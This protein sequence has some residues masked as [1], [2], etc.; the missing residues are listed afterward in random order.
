MW[1]PGPVRSGE[2]GEGTGRDLQ[3]NQA[4]AWFAPKLLRNPCTSIAGPPGRLA[5]ECAAALAAYLAA[6][7]L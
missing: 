5:G 3:V 4:T 1:F 7:A 2:P 6:T